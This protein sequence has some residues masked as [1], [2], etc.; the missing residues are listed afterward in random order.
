MRHPKR[1]GCAA[2]PNFHRSP[3]GGFPADPSSPRRHG[4]PGSG[5]L[6]APGLT[7]LAIGVIYTHGRDEH[8]PAA[9]LRHSL[10]REGAGGDHAGTPRAVRR[11]ARENS[12]P[13]DPLRAPRRVC[14]ERQTRHGVAGLRFRPGGK[15]QH[16]RRRKEERWESPNAALGSLRVLLGGTSGGSQP[17]LVKSCEIVC[18]LTASPP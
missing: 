4:P 17:A 5:A 2:V 16:R 12:G 1:S 18:F 14:T 8:P 13:L 3:A 10:P 15:E 7:I 9:N 6:L 11:T